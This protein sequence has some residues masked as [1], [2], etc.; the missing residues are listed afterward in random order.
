MAEQNSDNVHITGGT[1]DGTD[2]GQTTPAKVKAT[3][4]KATTGDITADNGDIKATN[5]KVTAKGDITTTNGA[6]TGDGSGLT[7]TAPNL[8]SG[9]ANAAQQLRVLASNGVGVLIPA[10]KAV[11]LYKNG[12]KLDVK[13]ADASTYDTSQ[14]IGVTATVIPVSGT[15]WVTMEGFISGLDTSAYQYGQILYLSGTTPGD[16][17][18]SEPV[19]PLYAVHVAYVM[20][21]NATT[22]TIYVNPINHSVNDDYFIGLLKINHGGT[23]STATPTAG[24]VAYGD[25]SKYVFNSAGTSG[26]LLQSNGSSAPTWVTPS[27]VAVTRFSAGTTGFTPNT[28]TGGDVTLGGTLVIANGGTNG[29]ATPTAGAVA[30][31]TGTAYAFTSAG[32][33]GYV[34]QSNGASAPTWVNPSALG[35]NITITDDTTTNSTFYPAFTS[36]TSGTITGEKVSSTKFTYNPSL[37]QIAATS[38]VG[39]SVNF[40]TSPSVTITYAEGKTFY[41]TDQHSLAYYNDVTNNMV[42]AGEEIQVKVINNTGSTIAAGAPVY[43]TSTSSGQT[44][45]NVALAKADNLTT[46]NVLGLAHMS[47]ANGAAGY[48]VTAGLMTGVNTGTFTVGDI[49]YLSPYSAGNFMNTYP[50]TGYAVPIGVVAYVNSSGTIYVTKGTSGVSSFSAGT[51][52]FTPSTAT[53]GAVTLAGTLGTANGGT[54]NTATPTAGTVAYGDGSKI[55]Y[56][57]AG[58]TGQ[59]LLS[60]GSSAPT[61]GTPAGS[62]TITND[63]SG[64]VNYNLAL[65]TASSGTITGEYVDNGV[66]TFNPSTGRLLSTAMTLSDGRGLNLGG[67]TSPIYYQASDNRVTMANYQSGGKLAFEVNGGFYTAYF[68]SDGTYQFANL[69]AK[70]VTATPKVVC[71]DSSGIIGYST[72]ADFTGATITATKFVGVSGGTF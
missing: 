57:A 13:L 51:T 70:S 1:I 45:P 62:L 7:G 59:A 11:Y 50:P 54:N 6:F 5:G 35:A 68:N 66:L 67:A 26:Q 2:I 8:T 25:G 14:V 17:S 39:D 9:N 63:A 34:L 30:Y 3:E 33:S 65:T 38:F 32:T 23:N 53:T 37:G 49:L 72:T 12:T 55:T 27:S 18:T 60:N 21:V 48:V 36:A 61:W 15:G 42:N 52:G 10:G 40:R 44:Y 41:N 19:S 46:A 16:L 56:T 47:I 20:T 24:A 58:T 22:G 28:L 64:N 4:V 43:V 69:Y 71:V 29:T 31:G